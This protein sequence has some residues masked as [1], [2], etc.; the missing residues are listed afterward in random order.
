MEDQDFREFRDIGEQIRN[1]VSDAVE[2]MDFG[3]LSKKISD[4]VNDALDEVRMQAA[5][6]RNKIENAEFGPLIKK[7]ENPVTVRVNWVGRIS[8]ILLTV[9]G[10][11]GS[12]IFGFFT[13][14]SLVILLLSA[15]DAAGWWSFG[16][17]AVILAGFL[18][19]LAEGIRRNGRVGRLKKYVKEIRRGKKSYC[20]LEQ[21]NKSVAKSL[22]F[23]RKDIRKMLRLGMLPDVRMD[24]EGTCL[25]LDD[26]TYRQYR[27]AQESLKERQQEERRQKESRQKESRQKEPL[28]GNKDEGGKPDIPEKSSGPEDV[29]DLQDSKIREA[30][31]RGEQYMEELDRLQAAMP[32][33]PIAPKLK[34]LDK[35]LERLFAVLKKHPDQLDELE[36]FMEYYLPTTVKLVT[37]YREFSEVEYPGENIRSA[38]TEIEA[39][40]DTINGAFEKLLDDLYQDTAFDVMTDASVLKSLLARDGLAGEKP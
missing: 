21:L 39:A 7:E 2:S 12:G 28:A 29:N 13:M 6:C 37:T 1:A 9:F 22:T 15:R 19:M 16:I 34:R 24:D 5:N 35:V 14:T 27:L 11:I 17:F 31:Q 40:L 32:K 30:V 25:M 20:E 18:L 4:S 36:R 3:Q 33:L 10:G 8:G 23:V 38:K 26:E